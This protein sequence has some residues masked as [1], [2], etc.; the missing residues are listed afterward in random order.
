MGA[1]GDIISA[2]EGDPTFKLLDITK[3]PALQAALNELL[4]DYGSGKKSGQQAINDFITKFQS[5][6]K[7]ANANGQQEIGNIDRY[8]NG[9]VANTLAAQRSSRATAVKAAG[10]RALALSQKSRNL[11]QL[12]SG[13]GSNSYLARLGLKNASDIGV[14]E[15]LDQSNMERGDFNWLEGQ[16]QALTG[17]RSAMQDALTNRILVPSRIQQGFNASNLGFLQG[18]QGVNNANKFYG[19]QQERT[20]ADRVGQGLD[21]ALQLVMDYYTGGMAKNPSSVNQTPM[22]NSQSNAAAAESTGP[23]GYSADYSNFRNPA[24]SPNSGS[25]WGSTGG[26]PNAGGAEGAGAASMFGGFA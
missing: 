3:S 2:F 15:A 24:F 1:F 13:G 5:D 26:M 22:F 23:G 6:S 25:S 11:S 20:V 19:L 21:G 8:F 17:R 14:N 18:W 4:K 12:T 7:T 16:K 9:D 10:D